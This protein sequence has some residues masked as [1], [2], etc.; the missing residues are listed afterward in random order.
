MQQNNNNYGRSLTVDE[1]I[2]LQQI[3]IQFKFWYHRANS[4]D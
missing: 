1:H 2:A 4:V 3:I